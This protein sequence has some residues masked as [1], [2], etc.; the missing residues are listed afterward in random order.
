MSRFL[1]YLL[2]CTML[3][4]LVGCSPTV[5]NKVNS[6]PGQGPPDLNKMKKAGGEPGKPTAQE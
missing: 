4:V 3:V 1:A 5:D 2:C 6:G